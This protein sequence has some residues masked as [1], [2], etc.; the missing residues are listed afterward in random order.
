MLFAISFFFSR[1]IYGTLI[2]TYAF[3]AA[4]RFIQ[5]ASKAHDTT[6]LVFVWIQTILCLSLRCLNFYW[7][8]LI[9]RK[10]CNLN[11]SKKHTTSIKT[12]DKEQKTS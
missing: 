4:P 6:S 11:K 9:L 7:G 1:L 12:V 10:L 8:F 5:L 3:L 2:C